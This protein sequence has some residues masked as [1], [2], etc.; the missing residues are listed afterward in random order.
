[1]DLHMADTQRY[2]TLNYD[3]VRELPGTTEERCY[4]AAKDDG[5]GD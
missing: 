1:M 4:F 5:S 3:V 2:N